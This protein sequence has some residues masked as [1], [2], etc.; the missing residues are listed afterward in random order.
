[1]EERIRFEREMEDLGFRPI[2]S[3]MSPRFAD[4]PVLQEVSRGQ[5]SLRQGDKGQAVQKIQQ[6]LID[7]GFPL[8]RFGVDGDFGNETLSAVKNYQRANGLSADG[9]IGPITIRSMDA[10]FATPVPVPTTIC[11]WIAVSTNDRLRYVMNLLVNNYH[12]PV[13]GAA[14]IVGNLLAESGVLPCRIEGSSIATPMRSKNFTGIMT[15]FSPDEVMNRNSATGVGPR[16]PGI[17][18]AQWTT[19]A[20]RTR[21]FQHTFGGHQLGS[22]ILFNMDA[23][24]DYLVDELRTRYAD[25]NARLM[26]PGVSLNDAS[27]DVV[28]Q[29]E[30]PGRILTNDRPRRK[31]PR[32]DPAV[33]SVFTQRRNMGLRAL[34]A[35]QTGNH[36]LAHF[37]I[38]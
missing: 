3:L 10:K 32:T 17:G 12:Y 30:I 27:D 26:A 2:G 23:Q 13:N 33:Q 38:M 4:D 16:L 25:L 34:Q 36:E 35:Y 28:Y 19:S 1:M 8:P 22:S 7:M 24:V 15:D 29:Y 6:A 37:G 11:T 21:L 14:G 18:L 20:R 9:I 31:L 5:R